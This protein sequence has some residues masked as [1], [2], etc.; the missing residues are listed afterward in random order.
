M[1]KLLLSVIIAAS[2]VSAM[3]AETV[4]ILYGFTSSDSVANYARTLIQEANSIQSKYNFIFDVKPGAASSIAARYIQNNPKNI[5]LEASSPFFIRPNLFPKDSHD[6]NQFQGLMLQCSAPLGVVS[7]KYK[8][9]D[10]IPKDKE[11]SIGI[12]GFGTTTHLVA[13]QIKEKFPNALIVPFKSSSEGQ[14]AMIAG[15]VDMSV[16]FLSDSKQWTGSDTKVQVSVL[17]ITGE[18][19]INGIPPLAKSGFDHVNKLSSPQLLV[20]PASVSDAQRAEWS[21]ILTKAGKAPAV[22]AAYANDFC[23]PAPIST[24]SENTEYFKEATKF[25]HEMVKDVKVETN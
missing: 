18:K 20:V 3:A 13:L 7:T 2:A 6:V 9:W 1:K 15:Q 25:W 19:T 8:A 23:S 5:I 21:E 24:L 22:Q 10:S 4:T 14:L 17:G 12:A 16:G 11:L